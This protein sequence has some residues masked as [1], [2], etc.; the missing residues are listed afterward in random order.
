MCVKNQCQIYF[1]FHFIKSQIWVVRVRQNYVGII[2]LLFSVVW[3]SLLLFD[4]V[5][6][7]DSCNL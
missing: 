4:H 2:L 7:I 1:V 6:D 3:I 5:V